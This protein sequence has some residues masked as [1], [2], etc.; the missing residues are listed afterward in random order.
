MGVREF[1]SSEHLPLQKQLEDIGSPYCKLH[2]CHQK[3]SSL[4]SDSA[5]LLRSQSLKTCDIFTCDI[6][7]CVLS[8]NLGSPKSLIQMAIK[9]ASGY[10]NP[11]F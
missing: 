11:P 9:W 8:Q 7:T 4:V 10:M 1:C 6:F 5:L 2:G 3:A